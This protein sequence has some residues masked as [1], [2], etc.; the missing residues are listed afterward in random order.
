MVREILHMP[1]YI[2]EKLKT[3]GWYVAS[4]S[5]LGLVYLIRERTS[6]YPLPR[7][8][9]HEIIPFIK[10]AS[11]KGYSYVIFTE[12][13]TPTK[14]AKRYHDEIRKKLGSPFHF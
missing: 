1:G 3:K 6:L 12:G 4:L 2:K 9:D 10:K 7:E 5:E 13:I 11:E 14:A 8:E